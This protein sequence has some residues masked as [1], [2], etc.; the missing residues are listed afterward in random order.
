MKRPLFI[1]AVLLLLM[2]AISSCSNDDDGSRANDGKDGNIA[3]ADFFPSN[4][5]NYW[6]YDISSRASTGDTQSLKDSLY[7][8]IEQ[9]P[10]FLLRVNNNLDQ[11][12]ATMNRFLVGKCQKTPTSLSI[13]GGLFSLGLFKNIEVPED[14]VLKLVDLKEK[15]GKMMSSYKNEFDQEIEGYTVKVSYEYATQQLDTFKEY[16]VKDVTYNNV[17]V[18]ALILNIKA[19]AIVNYNGT[20]YPI[21]ILEDKETMKITCYYADDIG[22]VR[23]ENQVNIKL[24]QTFLDILKAQDIDTSILEEATYSA[25]EI[26]DLKRYNVVLK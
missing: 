3:E 24:N 19:V 25:L 18:A 6:I 23:A 21:N 10:T 8:E 16:T 5:E 2:L 14:V 15:N 7:V 17:A 1:P 12:N 26:Q 20:D 11:A 22:L 9:K 13:N 4:N